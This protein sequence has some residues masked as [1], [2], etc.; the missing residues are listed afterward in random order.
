MMNVIGIMNTLVDKMKI[1]AGIMNSFVCYDGYLVWCN[2]FYFSMIHHTEIK[3]IAPH[4]IANFSVLAMYLDEN[5]NC[6]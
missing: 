4:K 2:I 1:L 6:Y 3:N 5:K